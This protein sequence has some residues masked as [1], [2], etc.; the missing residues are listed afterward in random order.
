[1]HGG[2]GER[3]GP[4]N[5]VRCRLPLS[6]TVTERPSDTTNQP[7]QGSTCLAPTRSFFPSSTDRP[8]WSSSR[9]NRRPRPVAGADERRRSKRRRRGNASSAGIPCGRATFTYVRALRPPSSS[10]SPPAS[11]NSFNQHHYN[12]RPSPPAATKCATA[13]PAY[14]WSTASST[15]CAPC[16]AWTRAAKCGRRRSWRKRRCVVDM[17]VG[18]HKGWS[19]RECF[20][21]TL[22]VRYM[23]EYGQALR[24]ITSKAD[25]VSGWE[26]SV[27]QSIDGLAWHRKCVL[28]GEE[29]YV[30]PSI[31][32]SI[33][34]ICVSHA[35]HR[36]C[37]HRS[38][39]ITPTPT[40]Q[41]TRT[42]NRNGTASSS[43]AKPS[44]ATPS[45]P[46]APRPA[47][48]RRMTTDC[49]PSCP[50][51][52]G[53]GGASSHASITTP[54]LRSLRWMRGPWCGAGSAG[55]CVRREWWWGRRRRGRGRG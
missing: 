7:S 8:P 33:N 22:T 28:I 42:T 6:V 54:P 51:P 37:A 39:T 14:R 17:D 40:P 3:D 53:T 50:S 45:A 2:V 34:L 49:P 4:A 10:P 43:S 13:A 11:F 29:A 32:R 48:T 21:R 36:A 24:Y 1:M 26:A 31:T 27:T 30:R 12:H 19:L 25:K 35:H 15:V 9:N 5:D 18:A 23:H 38:S 20:G 46:S 55:R 41:N 44:H 47:A 52:P 16:H